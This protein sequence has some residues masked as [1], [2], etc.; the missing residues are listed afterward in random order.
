MAPEICDNKAQCIYDGTK[1]D[2]FAAGVLLFLLITGRPPFKQAK[3]N[4]YLYQ[5]IIEGNIDQFW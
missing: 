1:A 4:D 3:T 5:N 2:I